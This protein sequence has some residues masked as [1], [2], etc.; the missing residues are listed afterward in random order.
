MANRNFAN[1]GKIMTMHVAPVI[2]NT[3]ILIG[4]SGAVTSSTNSTMITS[5]TKVS[6]GIYKLNLANTYAAVI[7][8][9]GSA[10]SPVSGL[11]GIATIEIQNAPSASV[12][13]FA[14]PSLTVKTLDITG[15]VADPVSGSVISV[16]ALVNNSSVPT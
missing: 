4:T 8:A 5:V 12:S 11:S 2:I 13:N 7:Q 9:Q 14:A 16:M 15:V 10:S 3:N 1:G 6:T